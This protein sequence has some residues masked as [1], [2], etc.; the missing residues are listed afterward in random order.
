MHIKTLTFLF[1]LVMYIMIGMNR[2]HTLQIET[3]IL[4]DKILSHFH[5]Y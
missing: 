4:Y 1:A 2:M 3:E 5:F